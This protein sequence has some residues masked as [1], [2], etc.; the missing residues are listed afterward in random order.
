MVCVGY[1]VPDSL[2]SITS[3]RQV[4]VF[5]FA[6]LVRFWESAHASGKGP[7]I[8]FPIPRGGDFLA[9]IFWI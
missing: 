3:K 1:R 7:F 6:Y 2:D 4:I 8:L 9:P 5:G